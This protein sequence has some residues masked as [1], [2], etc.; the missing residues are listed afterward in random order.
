[1]FSSIYQNAICNVRYL[2]IHPHEASRSDS[3]GNLHFPSRP[4]VDLWEP[5]H[6]T[7]LY[8]TL[9]LLGISLDDVCICMYVCTVYV[10]YCTYIRLYVCTDCM[11]PYMYNIYN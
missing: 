7:E 10:M 8:Y 11:Y 6:V 5:A 3:M 1:M 2:I 9:K 4:C